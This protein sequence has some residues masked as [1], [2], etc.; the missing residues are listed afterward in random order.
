MGSIGKAEQQN[1]PLLTENIIFSS[2]FLFSF[3]FQVRGHSVQEAALRFR[4]APP[5]HQD[6]LQGQ[7][8]VRGA[9]E[10]GHQRRQHTAAGGGI[11]E[12]RQVLPHLLPG[13]LLRVQ[14]HLL[15]RVHP[16]R[17]PDAAALFL[18]AAAAAEDGRR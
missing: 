16:V 15:A 6:R 10:G 17:Q 8:Q 5:Q 14:H 3:F 13:T 11:L 18:A 9:G 4:P 1:L 12:D 2:I 7:L